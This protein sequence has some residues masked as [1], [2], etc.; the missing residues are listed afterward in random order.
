MLAGCLAELSNLGASGALVRRSADAVSSAVHQRQLLPEATAEAVAA[1]HALRVS[2][3]REVQQLSV[4]TGK[5][6]REVAAG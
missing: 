3:L 6:I 1:A 2:F 4:Q 5:A